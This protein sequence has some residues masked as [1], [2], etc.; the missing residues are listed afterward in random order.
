MIDEL[1]VGVDAL[2]HS[3]DGQFVYA[4]PPFAIIREVINKI[5]SSVRTEVILVAPW[6]PQ[7]KWLPDLYRLSVAPPRRLP[8]WA[9]LLSQPLGETLHGNLPMLALTAWHLSSESS[10]FRASLGHSP[11]WH[12]DATVARLP[13]CTSLVGRS[14]DPGAWE[15]AFQF[16]EP[17]P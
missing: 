16:P 11:G 7:R 17:L 15:E 5:I 8:L 3:W 1:A 9:D 12:P 10:A 2:L 14:F 13:R 4:F 6:W